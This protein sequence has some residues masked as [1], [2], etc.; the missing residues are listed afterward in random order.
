MIWDFNYKALPV[1][2]FFGLGKLKQTKE[3]LIQR[4]YSKVLIIT[5]SSREK[6]GLKLAEYLGEV[7]IG[8]YPN[9]VIHVPVEVADKAVEYVRAHNVDS[10]LAIGGGSTIGLAKAV[11]LKTGVPIIAIP[12]TYSGSE[13]TSIYGM[14]DKQGKT[15]GKDIKVLPKVVIYDPELSLTLPPKVSYCSGMNAMAHAIEALYAK[16]K[17]PI[18]SLMAVESI[19]HLKS[20]L[21]KIMKNPLNILARKNALYGSWL[22]GV[23]LGSVGMSIHHKICHTLGGTFNLPHSQIHAI[24]LAYSVQYNRNA[25]IQAMDMLVDVMGVK[26]RE[27]LGLEIYRLNEESGIE[28]SLKKLGLPKEGPTIVAKTICKSPYYNPREYNFDE[29]ESLLKRAYQ[30]IPPV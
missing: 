8:V 23:C 22:A 6:E 3:L 1:D 29:L 19:K 11:A 21:P 13:M 16:D 17:N 27:E 4:G 9:A 30:G 25:D 18:T 14:T 7:C 12:T 15:T 5:T 26:N 10:C 28:L 2:V 24:M 20:S